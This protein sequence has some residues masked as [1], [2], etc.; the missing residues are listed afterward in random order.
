MILINIA[1]KER[2][3]NI[4]GSKENQDAVL[5]IAKKSIVL[6]KNDDELLPLKK[7]NQ[8]IAL[9]GQLANDKNSSIGN[10]RGRGIANSAVSVLEGLKFYDKEN[11]VIYRK[12]VDLYYGET[13]FFTR[14]NINYNDRSGFN[15][16]RGSCKIF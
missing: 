15:R 10:W 13:N 9:I 7:K 3:K 4:L 6:L 2:E 12:G 1:M 16:A 11:K 5:D 8:T 14:V